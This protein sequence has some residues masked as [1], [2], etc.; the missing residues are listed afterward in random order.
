VLTFIPQAQARFALAQAKHKADFAAHGLSNVISLL[1]RSE[2]TVAAK[3]KVV[4]AANQELEDAIAMRTR[5]KQ[6]FTDAVAIKQAADAALAA[7]EQQ[8]SDARPPGP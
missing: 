7:L 1:S 2:T 4:D 6:Q 5:F 8:A 3:Q